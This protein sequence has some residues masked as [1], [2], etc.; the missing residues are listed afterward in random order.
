MAQVQKTGYF[1]FNSVD[2]SAYG[3]AI[4]EDGGQ[5]EAEEA[6]VWG[7]AARVFEPGL[8]TSR[9]S[10]RMRFDPTPDATLDA[11]LRAATKGALA[12][13]YSSAAISATNP[14]FQCTA[15]ITA[16]D[17]GSELGR[18]QD[19]TVSFAFTTVVTRDITP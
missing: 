7:G 13:R 5:V 1:S 15:F 2:Y 16:Y 19:V 6:T 10:V 8:P 4:T 14:E 12:W 9:M 3:V 18:V 11:A 17:R